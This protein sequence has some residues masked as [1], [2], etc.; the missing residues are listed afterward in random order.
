MDLSTVSVVVIPKFSIHLL[1][2]VMVYVHT[3]IHF[4]NLF[5][6]VNLSLQQGFKGIVVN[7]LSKPKKKISDVTETGM[8]NL[9]F[10]CII[11]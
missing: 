11:Y 8:S 1:K 3:C 10:W 9:S 7:D 4:Y 6:V 5:I 2:T